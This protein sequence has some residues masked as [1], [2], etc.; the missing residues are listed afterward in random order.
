MRDG[1]EALIHVD[2]RLDN[3]LI[4]EKRDPPLICA[5]DWQ[6]I[7]VGNPL[8]DVAYFMGAG[9][10]PDER[11]VYEHQIVED[12]YEAMCDGGIT[13]YTWTQCWDDY[14]RG[15]FA[16]FMVTVIAAPMVE[17]TERGDEMFTAM[18]CR[19]ARHALDLGADEFL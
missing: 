14:R 12:Y 10:Q 3:L 5:V 19:H 13:D 7:T 6:S 15:T 11:R 8:S 9:M 4:D 16:G 17:Q 18:A 2:Y 1:P